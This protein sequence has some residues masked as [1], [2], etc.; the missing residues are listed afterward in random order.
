[1]EP[2]VESAID[3]SE[4]YLVDSDM[5]IIAE[6]IVR[7]RKC[8][9]LML[10]RNAITGHG[11]STLISIWSR[12]SQLKNVSLA[13]NSIG[14]T[15][16]QHLLSIFSLENCCL[17]K[18]NLDSNGITDSGAKAMAEALKINRS[19]QYLSIGKNRINDDG[20]KS[21]AIS[22][23]N[24]N[25]TLKQLSLHDNRLIQT[26]SVY[27]FVAMIQIH[28]CLEFLNLKGCHI[29]E[30]DQFRLLQTVK[31]KANFSLYVI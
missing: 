27:S 19:L 12:Y 26:S 30:M 16:V 18:L 7:D 1:M 20:M 6:H 22:I 10:D 31:Y 23:T 14:D 2:S 11:I 24:S 9:I 25:K 28:P 17:T 4:R 29:S 3:L 5:T 8:E 21:L 13:C 15:G